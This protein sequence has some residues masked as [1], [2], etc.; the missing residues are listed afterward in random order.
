MASRVADEIRGMICGKNTPREPDSVR[1]KPS[2][3]VIV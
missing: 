3:S 2:G 1:K